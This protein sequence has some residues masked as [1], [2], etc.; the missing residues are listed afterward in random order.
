MRCASPST[1]AEPARAV[2]VVCVLALGLSVVPMSLRAQDAKATLRLQI[3]T[4]EQRTE[5]QRLT[6]ARARFVDRTQARDAVGAREAE[7]AIAR[8]EQNL[9]ALATE[10]GPAERAASAAAK[11]SPLTPAST[12]A[13]T[14]KV[15]A[16]TPQTS[17]G[18]PAAQ[19]ARWWD[20]YDRATSIPSAPAV[21]LSAP[22]PAFF[23]PTPKSATADASA[24]RAPSEPFQPTARRLP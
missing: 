11:T 3:L 17:A 18:A 8:H 21:Q 12:Q 22:P 4:E 15:A 9:K 14:Q 2:L 20:V 1:I 13:Q 23:P 10:L 19:P 7:A 6:D 16:P 24:S 5:Q